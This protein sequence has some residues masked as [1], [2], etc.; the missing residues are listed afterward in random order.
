[1]NAAPRRRLWEAIFDSLAPPP[2]LTV[3]EWAEKHRILSRESS[4]Q[5]GRFEAFEYQVEPMDAPLSPEVTETV[6]W[7]GS[8]LGKSECINNLAG[9]FM[10]ADPAPQLL[11]QPTIDLSKAYSTER[12]APMIRDSPALREIVKDPRS[13]DSGNTTLSKRYPGGNIAFVGANAPSGLAG[14]PR[15]VILLDEID[16][17]PL[18]AGS[19]GDPCA[20]A[21]KRAESFPSAVKVKTSTATIKG[22]S[23]IEKLY[24]ASDKRKWFIACPKCSHEYVLMWAQ[25]QWPEGKPEEAFLECPKC[26]AHLDDTDR[27]RMVRGGR[28]IATAPFNGIRGFWINGINTLFRQHKGY[29]SRLHEFVADFHAAKDGGKDTMR[30]WINTFLAET[31]EEEAQVINA[32][33]II[34]RAEDYAPDALPLDVL[35]A[36]AAFDVQRIRIE[37][38]VK[39]WGRE[40]ESW[41][42]KKLVFDGDTEK[43]EVWALLDAALLEEFRREDGVPL[44][45]QRVFG[46]MGYRDKRVLAFCSPRIGR[47]VYPCKGINRVGLNVPPLLPAKPNRNNRARIPHWNVGVTVAKNALYDRIELPTP[48]PRT[49]H[50]P[51]DP[52]WGYDEDYYRQFT[53]EKRR[54]KYAF[55]QPYYIFEKDNSAARNEALDLNVYNLAAL[56]S[57]FPIAWN[58]LAENLKAQAEKINA[59]PPKAAPVVGDPAADPV[60]IQKQIAKTQIGRTF[61]RRSGFVQRWR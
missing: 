3:S 53:I 7:W 27:V 48:G 54:L 5:P 47:G 44:K 31:Y 8:Q 21:D 16:R 10:H 60:H 32:M 35:L 58:K 6:L 28:W 43:D 36:T 51:S 23:K 25:V 18:S 11:V 14:R 46:D 38:E 59:E 49:M 4:S 40:E 52:L 22:I 2:A 9:F 30:V 33:Q 29:R 20:L 50:F 19:E 61:R 15:R 13:R 41:G 1:M 39:G 55:G 26:K 17:F 24:E 12:I 34:E 57:L 37:C 56:H 45:V 42:I